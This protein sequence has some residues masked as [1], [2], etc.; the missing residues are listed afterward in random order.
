M[1]HSPCIHS[2]DSFSCGSYHIVNL[3]I[4]ANCLFIISVSLSLVSVFNL[5]SWCDSSSISLSLYF[6]CRLVFAHWLI[7]IEPL[8]IGLSFYIESSWMY[9]KLF[10][11]QVW[12]TSLLRLNILNAAVKVHHIYYFCKQIV[13]F[14]LFGIH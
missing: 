8:N 11:A 6:G 3:H 2:V 9:Y 5:L 12:N 1:W 7:I 14:S 10:P 4:G 13:I